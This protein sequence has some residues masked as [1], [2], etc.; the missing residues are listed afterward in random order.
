MYV[1]SKGIKEDGY[2]RQIW[3]KVQLKIIIQFLLKFTCTEGT[4][5]FVVFL[6]DRVAVPPTG[7]HGFIGQLQI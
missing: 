4:V 2:R 1:T 5:S 6:E 7:F 3:I